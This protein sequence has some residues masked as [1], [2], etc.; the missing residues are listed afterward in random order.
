[1]YPIHTVIIHQHI[2]YLINKNE[3]I[4]LN[5]QIKIPYLNIQTNIVKYFIKNFPFIIHPEANF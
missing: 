2:L 1:M 4:F 5:F 3:L